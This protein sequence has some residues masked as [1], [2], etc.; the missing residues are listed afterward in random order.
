MTAVTPGRAPTTD[1]AWARSVED[2]LRGLQNPRTLRVGPWVLSTE[3]G[4]GNLIAT[5]PGQAVVID[6][7]GATEVAPA[8]VSLA[9]LVTE[10]QLALELGDLPT[11]GGTGIESLFADL[12]EML[13]GVGIDPVGALGKLAEFFKIELGGPIDLVRLPLLPLAHIRNIVTELIPDSFFDNPL[14]LLNVP[15]WDWLDTDTAGTKPGVAET[16]ADGL[17]H[18]IYS[19]PIPVAIGDKLNALAKAKW[20]NLTTSGANPVR[21]F[22]SFYDEDD[23]MIGGPVQVGQTGAAGSSVGW[24]TMSATEIEPPVGAAYAIQELTVTTAATGGKVRFGQG[25]LT[26]SGLLPTG[27]VSGL[28]DALEGLWSGIAARIEEWSDLLDVF[29][30][31]AVGSGQGQLTDVFNRIRNLNP[32]NGLFDASK[33]DNMSGL[34]NIPD[35][36]SKVGD[37]GALVDKATGALSGAFQAGDVI[38]NAG[39][40]AAEHTMANLFEMITATTRKVQALETAA[41]ANSVGGRQ[42]NINFSDY[43]DGAFPA[44][45]FNIT[46]SGPGTS[47]LG[48]KGGNAV[49]NMVNNGYRRATLRYPTPTLTSFQVVR[50]TMATPPQQGTNVR[51][52]SVGRAN[53]AMTDYVFARG[54]CTGFLQYRGDIGIVRNGVEMIWASNISLTWSLDL[55]VIM[56]VGNNPRRHM[57]LSGDTVVWDGIEPVDKQSYLDTDHMYWGS[58]SETSGAQHPGEIA[59]AST[60]DNAPPAV[61]GTTF[62]ASRRVASDVTIGTGGVPVVPNFYETVDYISPDLIYRPANNCEIEVS[63]QG[64]YIVAWRALHGQYASGSFGHGLLFKNGVRFER[65]A[66]GGNQ[67]NLGFSV[68]TTMED[69]TTGFAMVPMNPGDKL[70]PG[71]AFSSSMGNTGDNVA[72]ADGSQSWFAVTRVGI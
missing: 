1:A 6:G 60:V 47:T 15:D 42:F 8:K 20:L 19:D 39:L 52:W 50:G 48:I 16:T 40:S 5:R 35:G 63:K 56:G 49:W 12:Y 72:L 43:P 25:S 22:L 13:T 18:T 62:R 30:G 28:V 32:L 21:M 37:L 53:S 66:W 65:W 34:P 11:G 69:A 31:F 64:T 14:T 23:A 17:T 38:V 33:L 24:V 58:V 27:Y 67:L 59:G 70:Q 57:V 7:Q 61:V 44:G 46:Y 54:Y 45:L 10:E 4:T 3:A 26:K 55:R 29:G 9:G 71:F 36:L 51:I 68:N 41:T 2:R